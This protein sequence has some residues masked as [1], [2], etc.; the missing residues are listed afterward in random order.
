MIMGIVI[1]YVVYITPNFKSE[2]SEFP[3]YFYAL[4][5][6]VYALHQVSTIYIYSAGEI[7][8]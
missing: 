7:I 3:L 4:M 6:G 1:G 5:I 8:N 2:D